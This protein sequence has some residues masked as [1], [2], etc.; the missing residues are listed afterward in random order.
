MTDELVYAALITLSMPGS[1]ESAEVTVV[2]TPPDNVTVD[3]T[4]KP[5][6]ECTLADLQ[7]LHFRGAGG[8]GHGCQRI[9]DLLSEHF[10]VYD[11]TQVFHDELVKFRKL[12]FSSQ[13]FTLISSI[14]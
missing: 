1:G 3:G 4:V 11:N 8:L 14:T 10:S 13:L 12:L 9:H 2:L 7:A 5:L 6:A